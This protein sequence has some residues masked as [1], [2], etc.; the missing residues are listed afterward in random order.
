M[1]TDNRPPAHIMSI[2][3][4]LGV[5]AVLLLLTM[6]TLMGARIS[7]GP[8]EIWVTLGIASAKATLVALYFMHLR[9]D[10][11][12]HGLVFVASLPLVALFLILTLMDLQA[13]TLQ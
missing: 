2:G 1:S 12:F 5:Y 8:A 7:F 11:S 4:L 10:K 13:S 9:H 6:A 3:T